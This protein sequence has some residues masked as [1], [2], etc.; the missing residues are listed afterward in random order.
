[1]HIEWLD[2]NITAIKYANTES[3]HSIV[4]TEGVAMRK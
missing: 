3:M 4:N 2:Q 1:M